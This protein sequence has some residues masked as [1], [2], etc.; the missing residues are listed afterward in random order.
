MGARIRTIALLLVLTILPAIVF[1]DAK[2]DFE[3]RCTACHGFGIAGAPKL[4][5]AENW[6]KRIEKGMDVLYDN[7]INGYSGETG[8]MPPRGG[9]ASLSDQQIKLIVDYMVESSR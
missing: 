7:A 6:G 5:D 4:G 2:S 3:S 1:A 9:F 8:T